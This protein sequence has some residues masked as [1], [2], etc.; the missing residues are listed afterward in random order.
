M[1]YHVGLALFI[2][3]YSLLGVYGVHE[4]IVAPEWVL[5]HW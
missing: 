3:I 1:A 4:N 5:K 2:P